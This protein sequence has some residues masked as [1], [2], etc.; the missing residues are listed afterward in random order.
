ML[1]LLRRTAAGS[2]AAVAGMRLL[3]DESLLLPTS[4]S[5]DS[6]AALHHGGIAVLPNVLSAEDRWIDASAAASAAETL[7]ALAAA[8]LPTVHQADSW[9]RLDNLGRQLGRR[10]VAILAVQQ[11]PSLSGCAEAVEQLRGHAKRPWPNAAGRWSSLNLLHAPTD[12]ALDDLMAQATAELD[13]RLDGRLRDWLRESG[14]L[15]DV[16]EE[17]EE[18]SPLVGSG[19]AATVLRAWSAVLLSPALR[20]SETVHASGEHHC[21]PMVLHRVALL[22]PAA[23]DGNESAQTSSPGA[24]LRRR[25]QA[26]LW[27]QLAVPNSLVILLPLPPAPADRRR[28]SSLSEALVAEPPPRE[29]QTP[30]PPPSMLIDERR[31]QYMLVDVLPPTG[32]TGLGIP[33]LRAAMRIRIPAGAALALDGRTRW[34]LVDD[35]S[36]AG[37]H[38]SCACVLFEYRPHEPRTASEVASTRLFDGVS[39]LVRALGTLLT[40]GAAAPATRDVQL[41]PRAADVPLPSS[42]GK[43]GA[44]RT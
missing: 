4:S 20:W 13:A 30:S 18:A 1:R 44:T 37:A 21:R 8:C 27:P 6:V 19:P 31:N 36:L 33:T 35:A 23:T 29:V 32:A 2:L 12:D 26:V 11:E 34:R 7:G 14:F 39:V 22:V 40:N 25:A 17:A 16:G 15:E 43:A 3:A 10:A 9:N 42:E 28:L 38:P 5:E 41:S 24:Q